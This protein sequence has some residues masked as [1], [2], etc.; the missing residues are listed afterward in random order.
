MDTVRESLLVLD[1]QLRIVLA[2]HSF[3]E[4]FSVSPDVTEG[5]SLYKL[6]DGQWDFA[7]SRESFESAH[8]EGTCVSLSLPE[9]LASQ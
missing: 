5:R 7:Q 4:R 9:S 1:A 8:G 2:N 6:A 3:Y